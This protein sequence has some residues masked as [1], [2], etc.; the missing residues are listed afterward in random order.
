[1]GCCGVGMGCYGGRRLHLLR[2]MCHSVVPGVDSPCAKG[3]GVYSCCMACCGD[4]TPAFQRIVRSA[5]ATAQTGAQL[6][7]LKPAWQ[8]LHHSRVG[9][10]RLALAALLMRLRVSC[11]ANSVGSVG[12]CASQ[13]MLCAGPGLAPSTGLRGDAA[14]VSSLTSGNALHLVAKLH[15]GCVCTAGRTA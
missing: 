1:M 14:W 5:L 8:L 9:C 13:R 4:S 10:A 15:S 6:S 3:C 11:R 2:C 12:C 7:G